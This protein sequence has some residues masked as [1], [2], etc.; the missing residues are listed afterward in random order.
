VGALVSFKKILGVDN[1][2][3]TVEVSEITIDRGNLS[4]NEVEIDGF[5][6]VDKIAKLI[7]VLCDKDNEK[8]KAVIEADVDADL[9]RS[10]ISESSFDEKY[11]IHIYKV[12]LLKIPHQK[13]YKEIEKVVRCL[14]DIPLKIFKRS[15]IG[16]CREALEDSLIKIPNPSVYAEISKYLD[17]LSEKIPNAID[18]I[19][20]DK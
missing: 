7:K 8:I 11:L 5:I 15:F 13:S 2:G 16:L 6:N 17:S 12:Y 3:Q 1:T 18:F 19:R 9:S 10:L 14:N 20:E 4:V